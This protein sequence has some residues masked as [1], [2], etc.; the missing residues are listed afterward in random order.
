MGEIRS[1][2]RETVVLLGDIITGIFIV[3]LS[4]RWFAAPS[5]G[6][7]WREFWLDWLA[8]IP[9]FRPIRALRAVRVLRALRLLRLYR[10]GVLAHRFA[11]TFDPR[12]FEDLLREQVAG[13]AG[14][15]EDAILVVPDLYRCLTNLLEGGKVHNE[16]RAMVCQAIAYFI[17]PFE[18]FPKAAFGAQGYLDQAYL[19]LWTL[20]RLRSELPEHIL[21]DAWEGEGGMAEVVADLLPRVELGLGQEEAEKVKRYVGVDRRVVEKQPA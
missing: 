6:A 2:T 5:T 9:V 8:V 13:Y 3:E 16:A 21:E 18:L 1:R 15:H 20:D 12:Q 11:G 7:H 19:C 17:T 10:F 4:L 14:E